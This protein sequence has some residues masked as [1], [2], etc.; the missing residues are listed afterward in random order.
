MQL[1]FNLEDLR[2]YILKESPI[3]EWIAVILTLILGALALLVNR[4]EISCLNPN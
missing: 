4:S 1:T 2:E 3:A